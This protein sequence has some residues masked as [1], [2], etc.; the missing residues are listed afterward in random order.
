MT[1]IWFAG[2]FA[3][4]LGVSFERTVRLMYLQRHARARSGLAPIDREWRERTLDVVIGGSGDVPLASALDRLRGITVG[5]RLIADDGRSLEVPSGLVLEIAAPLRAVNGVFKAPAQT[6]FSIFIST[7]VPG[8][9]PLRS[10]TR[11]SSGTRLILHERGWNPVREI[12]PSF[13]RR[14]RKRGV[15]TFLGIPAIIVALIAMST[16]WTWLGVIGCALLA[17]DAVFLHS[18]IVTQNC[19]EEGPRAAPPPR[20]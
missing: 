2:G 10:A 20:E 8:D 17:V 16:Q 4:A 15:A 6:P 3:V 13:D 1:W 5:F 18:T 11:I 9:G 12:E 14:W 7:L 19:T